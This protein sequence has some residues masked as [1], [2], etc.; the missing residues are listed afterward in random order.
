M[1]VGGIIS[2]LNEVR[3]V[4]IVVYQLSLIMKRC[5]TVC[6]IVYHFLYM[7]VLCFR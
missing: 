6:V 1:S 5:K 4:K 7:S 2:V 3:Q